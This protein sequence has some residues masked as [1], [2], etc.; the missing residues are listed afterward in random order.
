MLY[1]LSM[2]C[3]VEPYKKLIFFDD[4][5]IDYEIEKDRMNREEIMAQ[6]ET[7]ADEL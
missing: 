6:F 5:N 4:P 2:L 7:E 3:I 1:D